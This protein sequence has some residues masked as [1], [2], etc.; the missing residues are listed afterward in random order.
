MSLQCPPSTGFR[1]LWTVGP[2]A[3]LRVQGEA[4]PQAHASSLGSDSRRRKHLRDVASGQA[5]G[6][7]CLLD[8]PIL[9][10]RARRTETPR[11][12]VTK[13][14]PLK[15][16]LIAL[17]VELSLVAPP[18]GL[19]LR[20]VLRLLHPGLVADVATLAVEAPLT[21]HAR[22]LRRG[23]RRGPGVPGT[24]RHSGRCAR[25]RPRRRAQ[26]GVYR[27]VG[28][29]DRR[30]GKVIGG[31]R[32]LRTRALRLSV[33]LR[34]PFCEILRRPALG[35][36]KPICSSR[37]RRHQPLEPPSA[38]LGVLQPRLAIAGCHA[39]SAPGA[40]PVLLEVR[41]ANVCPARHHGLRLSRARDHDDP[42][43]LHQWQRL[44]D[45]ARPRDLGARDEV[46]LGTGSHGS[47]MRPRT[48]SESH[49][50]AGALRLTE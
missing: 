15:T 18:G 7:H 37:R 8:H 14:A 35:G 10:L 17:A 32:L 47:P 22:A 46:A 30:C 21:L 34:D 29:R 2:V 26:V 25:G 31:G 5:H 19:L 4:R 12:V 6:R 50:S 24:T 33:A 43:L 11:H 28:D 40:V 1:N 44:G 23:C 38:R 13:R 9:V 20:R 42:R 39:P 41:P 36:C 3:R 48:V 27:A 45:D 49:L 16:R